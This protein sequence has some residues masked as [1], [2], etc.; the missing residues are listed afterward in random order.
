MV[1]SFE[2]TATKLN[3]FVFIDIYV[4]IIYLYFTRVP[5]LCL[6][7]CIKLD[8]WFISSNGPSSDAFELKR[9][10]TE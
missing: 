2:L 1:S 6:C 4:S 10:I 8:I 9:S 5:K 7:N 3:C